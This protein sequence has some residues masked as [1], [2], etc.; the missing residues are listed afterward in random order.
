VLWAAALAHELALWTVVQAHELALQVVGRAHKLALQAAGQAHKLALQATGRTHP[1]LA[2]KVAAHSRE[3]EVVAADS[4][5]IEAA[6]GSSLAQKTALLVH[7]SP[8]PGA[9][10][11]HSKCSPEA[12]TCLGE[13]DDAAAC[14][15]LALEPVAAG[16][17]V[18]AAGPWYLV[19]GADL[20]HEA[21][22]VVDSWRPLLSRLSR[23]W[24][25]HSH[26][27]WA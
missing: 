9:A 18:K 12:A 27:V 14:S 26:A 19:A 23:P 3:I 21:G 25:R 8:E 24:W 17:G 4:R 11:L 2:L 15:S 1:K 7:L 10:P 22:A 16:L 6:A 5:V 13:I 20:F